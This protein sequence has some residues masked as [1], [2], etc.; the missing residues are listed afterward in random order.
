MPSVV[1]FVDAE[2]LHTW[3]KGTSPSALTQR[4]EPTKEN[5]LFKCDGI[6]KQFAGVVV[7]QDGPFAKIRQFTEAKDD[8]HGEGFGI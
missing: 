3:A 1:Q 5:S 4:P 2:P 6:G 8:Y 7:T